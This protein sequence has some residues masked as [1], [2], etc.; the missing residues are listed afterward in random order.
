MPETIN[1]VAIFLPML[2]LVLLTFI[3][4]VRMASG[5]GAAV[6]AGHDPDYYRAQLGAPEPEHAVVGVRHWG[7]L[8]EL[9]TL[10]Y[11]ACLTAFVLQAVSGWTLLFAWGWIAARIIQSAVHITYN[12]PNHRGMGFVLGVLFMLTLW[13]NIALSI[14]ARL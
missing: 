6:K 10:F 3:A 2:V 12:N 8:F 7:N 13:I 1:P 5:R 9:P 4:F 14:F 11:A